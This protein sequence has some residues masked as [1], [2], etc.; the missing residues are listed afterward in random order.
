[1]AETIKSATRVHRTVIG[2]R[3][4]VIATVVLGTEYKTEGLELTTAQLQEVGLPDGLVLTGFVVA[5][6]VAA[7]GIESQPAQLVVTEPEKAGQKVRIQL[8]ES[9]TK[10]ANKELA[11]KSEAAKEAILTVA[12]IG[13]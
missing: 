5:S 6:D 12:L 8:Y 7:K 1:M 13:R 3:Y 10:A 9:I 4:L 11:S 2:G